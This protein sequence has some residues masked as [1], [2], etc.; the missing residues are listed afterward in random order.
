MKLPE[1]PK[2]C[3]F[4]KE[5][6]ENIIHTQEWVVYRNLLKEHLAHL[7][8]EVNDH[9]RKHEDRFAAEALRAMDDSKKILD[10]VTTRIAELNQSIE[11]GGNNGK[12]I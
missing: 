3:L 9:L 10:L 5:Q 6:W 7:Q 8:K 12:R 1:T 4:E 2:A 11:Q